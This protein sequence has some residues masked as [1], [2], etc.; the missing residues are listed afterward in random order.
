MKTLLQHI[1]TSLKKA[2]FKI[3][4]SQ[5]HPSDIDAYNDLIL[6]SMEVK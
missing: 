2:I 3:K 6:D 4:A 5:I 1:K